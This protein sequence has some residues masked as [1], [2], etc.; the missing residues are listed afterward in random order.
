MI[1]MLL[2]RNTD[3]PIVF[4][5]DMEVWTYTDQLNGHAGHN[6]S[7]T[8]TT[9]F[10]RI[11]IMIAVLAMI[12][13]AVVILITLINIVGMSIDIIVTIYMLIVPLVAAAIAI[14]FG[15]VLVV[16]IASVICLF[17]R[18]IRSACAL[19]RADPPQSVRALLRGPGVRQLGRRL[20]VFGT[21]SL[22][23]QVPPQR[24]LRVPEQDLFLRSL[25]PETSRRKA[26]GARACLL[27]SVSLFVSM[28]MSRCIFTS[29]FVYVCMYI[30]KYLY[31]AIGMRRVRHA[32]WS[33]SS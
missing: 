9:R 33:I 21:C 27:I 23:T 28:F 6:K 14:V 16:A 29:V 15:I 1:T 18:A 12:P 10:F 13:I 8:T 26:S 22:N 20:D 19:G 17:L 32:T 24:G 4:S 2:I 31:V 3:A 11:I 25:R 5:S 30:Y 7:N